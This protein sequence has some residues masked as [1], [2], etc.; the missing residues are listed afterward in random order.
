MIAEQRLNL[1]ALAALNKRYDHYISKVQNV[2]KIRSET[3]ISSEQGKN[4]SSLGRQ[5]NYWIPLF[6]SI[7]FEIFEVKLQLPNQKSH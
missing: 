6:H 2:S 4:E 7:V 1:K 3:H 5:S